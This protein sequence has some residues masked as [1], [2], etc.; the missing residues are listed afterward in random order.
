M[1]V[2]NFQIPKKLQLK[3]DFKSFKC[4]KSFSTAFLAFEISSGSHYGITLLD[5]AAVSCPF[6]DNISR[7]QFWTNGFPSKSI[8]F[9]RG[10][11][12]DLKVAS[13]AG[14]EH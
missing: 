1:T 6:R 10:A 11:V 4:L 8:L 12:C 7:Q 9:K 3:V 14:R 13:S 5:I 2:F